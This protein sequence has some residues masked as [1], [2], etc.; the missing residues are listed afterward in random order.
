MDSLLDYEG[1]IYSIIS[2][3]PK[4]FDKD[5]L[6]QV[7]ML[8]LIDAYKHFDNSR[9][10]KFSSYAYY[11]IVGE[12]NKFIRDSSSI[13]VSKNLIDLKKSILKAKEVMTQKL[14]REPTNMELSLYLDVSEEMIDMAIISTD[15]VECLDDVSN[16]VKMYDETSAEILD[17]RSEVMRLPKEERNLILAR[18]YDEL[19]QCETSYKLGI[20]Q[21]QVSRCE[22]KILQKLR[23]RL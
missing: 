4:R 10:V 7:G 15:A 9:D 1:L 16:T 22:A 17:L 14:G 13:K 3:Y 11:Y 2:K 23:T 5:D 6:F 8:G 12:V 20:S 21:V 19:T 18:Y